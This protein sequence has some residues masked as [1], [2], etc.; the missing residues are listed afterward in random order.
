MSL[1]SVLQPTLVSGTYLHINI[2][3]D[4]CNNINYEK[5]PFKLLLSEGM[6]HMSCDP[7]IH[8]VD[9]PFPYFR[10]CSF[11]DEL[12]SSPS[13]KSNVTMEASSFAA[14]A[15]LLTPYVQYHVTPKAKQPPTW[16]VT[17]EAVFT[18]SQDISRLHVLHM[19]ML[20]SKSH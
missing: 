9:G 16:L 15:N 6:Q 12:G 8:E 19:C 1:C 17:T 18:G 14:L 7:N 3:K 13:Y 5:R 4:S 20:T 2:V 11:T 10:L